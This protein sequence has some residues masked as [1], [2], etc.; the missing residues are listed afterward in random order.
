MSYEHG[1]RGYHPR[2]A[3]ILPATAG[4]VFAGTPHRGSN[5]AAWASIATNLAKLVLK[6]HND[7][8]ITALCRGSETLERL[9]DSF[10]GIA[11]NMKLFSF[12]EDR[13]TSGIGKVL[14]SGHRKGVIADD[15]AD[16]RRRFSLTWARSRA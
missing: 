2:L 12:F 5:K 16:C 9:Q 11:A 6:D 1:H 10:S 15:Q 4:I 3:A 13:Q 7:L 8:I 14:L